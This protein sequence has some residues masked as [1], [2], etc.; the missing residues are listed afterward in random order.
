MACNEAVE[1]G[2][3]RAG[4]LHITSTPPEKVDAVS[5]AQ[6]NIQTIVHN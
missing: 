1:N 6:E 5:K 3:W 4:I 2:H